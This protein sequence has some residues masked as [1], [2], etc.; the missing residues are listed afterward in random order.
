MNIKRLNIIVLFRVFLITS[1]LISICSFAIQLVDN[2]LSTNPFQKAE[3][4]NTTSTYRCLG[5]GVSSNLNVSKEIAMLDAKARLTKAIINSYGK[6]KSNSKANKVVLTN[7]NQIKE[8]SENGD[9][10]MNISWV[11]IEVN[12]SEIFTNMFSKLNDS[13]NQILIKNFEKVMKACKNT[14]Y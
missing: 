11:I 14:L 12:K 6:C 3:Y 10:D 13:K 4:Q 1:L 5:K 7:I 8:E 9:N 2:Y